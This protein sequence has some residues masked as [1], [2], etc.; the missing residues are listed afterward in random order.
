VLT[1]QLLLLP[2]PGVLKTGLFYPLEL[3]R[4]RITA[5]LAK[6]GQPRHYSTIRQCISTTFAQVGRQHNMEDLHCSCTLGPVQP[7]I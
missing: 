7:L 6:A 1:S 3:S 5:D 2:Y 4:T